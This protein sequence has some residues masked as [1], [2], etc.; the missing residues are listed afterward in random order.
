MLPWTG[1]EQVLD[2]GTGRGL[3]LV[4]AAK[5]LTNG[6]S[7]GVDVWNPGRPKPQQR[8]RRRCRM[9]SLEGVARQSGRLKMGMPSI[10]PFADN[11]FDYVV[12]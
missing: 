8:V 1:A 11:S 10:I 2:I 12:I 3:L 5:L 4:G 7:F 6:K 9:P